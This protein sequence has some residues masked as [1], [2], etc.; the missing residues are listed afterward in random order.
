MRNYYSI[1]GISESASAVEIKAA[2]KA[3]AVK[4]H[5]DKN[6]ENPLMEELFKEVNHAYQVLSNPY[7]KARY[8]LQLQF[9]NQQEIFHS[10]PPPEPPAYQYTN[11][12]PRYTG[13]QINWKENWK[14][15]GYAFAF[16]FA[17]ASIIMIGVGIK[18]YYDSYKM[19]KFLAER[20]LTFEKAVDDYHSGRLDSALFAINNLGSFSNVEMDMRAFKIKAHESLIFNADHQYYLH[21]YTDAIYYYELIEKHSPKFYLPLQE[22]MAIT[23]RQIGRFG[24]A[25]KKLTEL[26]IIGYNKINLY[27]MKAE[28]FR[29]DLNNG[30]EALRYF[31]LASDMAI[32]Q[33][34]SV[35]GKAYPLVMSS[36]SV[37]ESHFKIYSGLANQYFMNQDYQKT[38]KAT[39][40][41]INMWPDSSANYVTAMKACIELNMLDLAC[42]YYQQANGLG[43]DQ[44]IAIKCK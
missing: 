27:L 25:L 30:E 35:Y 29:D 34:E 32:K 11:P 28:I 21:N 6:P 33:Y 38:L 39:A 9:G 18:E 23:Y 1:L 8:D 40:W 12:K 31:K 14:A 37:P 3:L 26:T 36:K 17:V 7:E 44:K 41:N 2:F 20:R 16:T 42:E 4:Y 22:R 43:Y 13:R 19:E 10:N 24:K 15:T 5:P